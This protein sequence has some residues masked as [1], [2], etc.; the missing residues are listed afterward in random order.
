MLPGSRQK[1]VMRAACVGVAGFLA[2]SGELVVAEDSGAAT[3]L[4]EIVSWRPEAKQDNR[5][6]LTCMLVRVMGGP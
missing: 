3:S 1:V 2:M 4:E 6:P 5:G